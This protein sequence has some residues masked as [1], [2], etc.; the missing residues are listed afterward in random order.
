MLGSKNQFD[1]EKIVDQFMESLNGAM[2]Q[3]IHVAPYH[4]YVDVGTHY[5]AY[6]FAAHRRG[7]S[8]IYGF[9]ASAIN[10]SIAHRILQQQN[11]SNYRIYNFAVSNESGNIVKLRKL[12]DIESTGQYSI[13]DYSLYENPKKK[14]GEEYENCMTISLDRIFDLCDIEHIDTMKVDIEGAEYDFLMNK[15]LSRIR[16]MYI[17]FHCGPT[18]NKELGHYLSKYFDIYGFYTALDHNV[19]N[20]VQA[21]GIDVE[22]IDFTQ[23]IHY[24]VLLNKSVPRPKVIHNHP[25]EEHPR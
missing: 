6:I 5:G 10:T 15:D 9:E 13:I 25:P 7:Y 12:R 3:G 23:E 24:M 19:V 21:G 16:T 11:V 4:T 1:Q 22:D 18:K 8:K 2:N 14:M 20:S 17:E